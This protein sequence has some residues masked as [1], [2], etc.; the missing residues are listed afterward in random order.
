MPQ[1]TVPQT[2]KPQDEIIIDA[3]RLRRA[4]RRQ[5]R[6]W[7][8]LGP[9]AAGLLLLA[10]AARVPRTYTSTTSVALQQPSGGGS[11]LALLTGGGSGPSKRY[12]GVLKSRSLAVAVER[13]VQLRQLYGAKTFP[14]EAD[15]ADFLT[16][17]VKPD[18]SATDGLLY[19]A[20]S[21]PGPPKLVPHSSPSARQVQD[22]AADTANAYAL[23]LKE[24]FAVSDT[25]QGAVLLRGADRE[26][27][28]AR[29]NYNDALARSL[30][31]TRV[32][33]RTDPRSAPTLSA[34][35]PSA[36]VLPASALPGGFSAGGTS[37][38]SA[39][40]SGSGTDPAT[41]SSVLPGLYAELNRV[42]AELSETQAVRATGQALID[43]QLQDL[44]RVPTDDPLL[45]D[46]RN[47][48][49]QDQV[50][51]GTLSTL[52]PPGSQNVNLVA[53]K[54]RLDF[55][56][57]DLNRQKAGIQQRLTTPDV[58]S[59]ETIQG[60]YARQ[61]KL[62]AQIASAQ[63]HL[64]VSRQL[65]GEAGRLSAEVGIQLD[66]LKATLDEAAKV[67]LNNASSLSRMTI[68][69]TAIPPANGEPGLSKLAAACIALAVLGFLLAVVW[70]Y[71]R[72]A[73]KPI[74]LALGSGGTNGAGKPNQEDAAHAT[75]HQESVGKL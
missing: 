5:G 42:Q 18:D 62:A 7:L 54:A 17:S 59:A 3:L 36:P 52:Y 49:T 39:S 67:R 13:R 24:Y 15:A 70:E 72:S 45:T 74:G 60:L 41:A 33:S 14:T 1:T 25:D 51:Y 9:L 10:L 31:F 19:I 71:L 4:F 8:W 16:K 47:R 6:L 20:V 38:S 48:V 44:S 29:A 21:L 2:I 64:G 35:A 50:A 75:V 56:Q 12:L 61:A 23:G 63:R 32:L 26:V 22:A 53:A 58:R 40:F 65:S 43:T 55:D 27:H 28:Q 66:V 57:A 11:A 37:S 68:I 73:P 30:E 46:V 34:S 69:D